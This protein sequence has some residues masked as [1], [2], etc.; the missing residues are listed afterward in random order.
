MYTCVCVCA[1]GHAFTC[2]AM[3]ARVRMCAHAHSTLNEDVCQ[4]LENAHL[5]W[6]KN[7]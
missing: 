1:H 7:A 2:V 6:D 5:A 4:L 3:C